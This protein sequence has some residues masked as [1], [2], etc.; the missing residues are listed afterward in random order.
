MPEKQNEPQ[1]LG[2]VEYVYKDPL[3]PREFFQRFPS[4]ASLGLSLVLRSFPTLRMNF[5]DKSPLLKTVPE[6]EV[7]PPPAPINPYQL[8]QGGQGG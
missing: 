6:S 3:W 1:R 7:Q 8:V 4:P 2:K 5:T